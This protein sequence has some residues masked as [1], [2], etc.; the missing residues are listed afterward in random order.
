[1][2]SLILSWTMEKASMALVWGAWASLKETVS[3][4][5]ALRRYTHC[6]SAA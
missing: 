2:A 6:A 4:D 3:E 5:A 1:M